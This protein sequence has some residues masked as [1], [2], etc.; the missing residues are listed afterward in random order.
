[1][2]RAGQEGEKINA[3]EQ[4][5]RKSNRRATEEQQKSNKGSNV[6]CEITGS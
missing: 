6:E 5:R 4:G 1:M 3:K 2:T